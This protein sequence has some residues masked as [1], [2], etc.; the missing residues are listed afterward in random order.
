[1][2]TIPTVLAPRRAALA[3]VLGIATFS[4][5]GLAQSARPAQATEGASIAGSI[6]TLS[7]LVLARDAQGSTKIL[8]VGSTVR[9]G[10]TLVTE[11]KGYAM[12]TFTDGAEILMKPDTVIALNR[13]VYDPVRP[14]LDRSVV[15]LVRG[16]FVSTPGALGKRSPAEAVIKTSS[17]NLQGAATL[18]LTLAP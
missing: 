18:N 9:E 3:I 2:K 4:Q 15:E 16:G 7:G 6:T 5:A 14:Q 11:S 1:M 10:D 8:A 12:V 13:F 17:G